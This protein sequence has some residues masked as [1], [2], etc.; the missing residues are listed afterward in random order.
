MDFEC[1]K[2]ILNSRF[3]TGIVVPLVSA[4]IGGALTLLGVMKTLKNE[5]QIIREEHNEKLKPILINY[6][7]S[8]EREENIPKY[9]FVSDGPETSKNIKGI[10]KN[11]DCGIAFIDKIVTENKTY[12][13]KDNSTVDKNTAF[14]IELHNLDNESLKFCQIF[15]HDILGNGYYYDAKFVFDDNREREIEIGNIHVGLKS[16]TR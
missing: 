2:E 16:K 4:G 8:F 5:N 15:C 3:V 6:T 1:L 11:T 7:C 10:F 9:I 12:L 13:P 14:I